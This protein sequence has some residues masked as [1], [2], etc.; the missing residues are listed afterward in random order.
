LFYVLRTKIVFSCYFVSVKYPC[1][2]RIIS[3]L[4]ALLLIIAS[5][6]TGKQFGNT[7][8]DVYY[9][10]K[11]RG[12][13][14]VIIRD[15]DVDS[16]IR[17]HPPQYGDPRPTNSIEETA[18]PNASIGYPEYKAKQDSLYKLYPHLSGFYDPNPS[19][20]FDEREAARE[21]RRENR[22]LRRLYGANNGL[23]NNWNIGLGWNNWGGWGPSWSIGLNNGWGWNNW[24]NGWGWNNWNNGWGWNNWN[25]GWGWNNW[26]CNA[27]YDPWWG[28]WGWNRPIIIYRDGESTA[29]TPALGRPRPSMGSSTPPSNPG[30]NT[31]NPAGT[32]AARSIG[33]PQATGAARLEN[34][35]GR[36]V[37]IP[38]ANQVATAPPAYKSYQPSVQQQQAT[39][40]GYEQYRP[41]PPANPQRDN[42]EQVAPQDN[43]YLPNNGN[44]LAPSN[45]TLPPTYNPPSTP[46]YSAPPANSGGRNIGGDG[47]GRSIGG[48]GGGMSRPATRPR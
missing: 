42:L 41:S 32:D 20:P 4:P 6:G 48:G 33:Q 40:Q 39:Q 43:R 8:D 21:A 16:L 5:C 25:N 22:R 24:N 15:V 29:S 37:Y 10:R 18:N 47:G 34:I 31:M 11:Q 46:R 1:M 38:P 17:K 28:G 14:A 27:W 19:P 36:I 26:G 30:M 12:N 2:N 7:D 13:K 35:N 3:I 44:Y 9:S 23:W 45:G